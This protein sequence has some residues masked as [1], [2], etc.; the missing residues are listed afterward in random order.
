MAQ[1]HFLAALVINIF[2]FFCHFF[3]ISHLGAAWSKNLTDF[4]RCVAIYLHLTLKNNKLSSWN[5][6]TIQC[7]KGW[8]N[9]LKYYKNIG[10]TTYAQ[11]FFLFVFGAIGYNLERAELICHICFINIIQMIFIINIGLK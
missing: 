4:G 3:F 6:W 10:L 2:G 5:E 1:G 11:T 8:S 9:H 7:F